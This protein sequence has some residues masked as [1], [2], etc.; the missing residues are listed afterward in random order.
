MLAVAVS[1]LATKQSLTSA[2]KILSL[3]LVALEVEWR[4]VMS[5]A[6]QAELA[7]Y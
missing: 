7:S 1:I 2:L 3:K 6:W 5:L 4:L